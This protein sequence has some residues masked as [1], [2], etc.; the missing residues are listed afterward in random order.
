MKKRINSKEFKEFKD[1]MQRDLNSYEYPF[2]ITIQKNKIVARWKTQQIQEEADNRATSSFSVTYIL[3]RDK[4]FCGGETLLIRD[5]YKPPMSTEART[6]FL[7]S[8][9]KNLPWRK[10]VDHKDWA[11]I[12]FDEDKLLS[13]IEHYLKDHDF[14][15]RPG[16]W[17]H[18]RLRWEE[19]RLFRITGIS[20]LFAG[21]FLLEG[22]LNS[23]MISECL[24][25]DAFFVV[26]LL[27]L[28][29]ATLL[30]LILIIIGTLMSLI[31]F[32]KMEF[33]DLRPE[34]GVKLVLGIIIVAWLLIPALFFLVH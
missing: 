9:P 10:R 1:S 2:V 34:V 19:G 33:Y 25:L 20:F 21:I 14:K 23:S 24:R 16:I 22:F 12:G 3:S 15:Y 32:G 28:L 6:V 13:I 31:G 4:T 11:N 18:K 30:P 27:L 5:T 26:A 8:T 17:N 29:C 7:L